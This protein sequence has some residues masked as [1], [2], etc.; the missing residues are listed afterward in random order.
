MKAVSNSATLDEFEEATDALSLYIIANGLPEDVQPKDV[1]T[2]VKVAY[3][4]YDTPCDK[5]SVC[6]GPKSRRAEAAYVA[7]LRELRKASPGAQ[8]AQEMS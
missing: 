8:G 6:D 4:D 1:A 3:L 7:F 2:K 5:R